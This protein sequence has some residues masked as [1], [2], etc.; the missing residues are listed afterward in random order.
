VAKENR[1]GEL[2]LADHV[3][4][5]WDRGEEEHAG[6]KATAHEREELAWQKTAL[7]DGRGS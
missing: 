7:P 4:P 6:D 1:V 2:R 5:V 3:T